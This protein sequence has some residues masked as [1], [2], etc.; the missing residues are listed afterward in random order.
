MKERDALLSNCG[1]YR[2]LLTRVW[3]RGR[4]LLL[5]IMLN[6]STADA[7]NND[8][9][10]LRVMSLAD[11]AGYG[12]I[13][14]TN[15]YAY[16]ATNP[17]NLKAA[18]A[19]IGSANDGY[20]KAALNKSADVVC[21]WGAHPM[22][23]RRAPAVLSLIRQAGKTPKVWRLTK[24]GLPSHPLYLPKAVRPFVWDAAA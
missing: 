18:S 5:V 10:I 22:A 19:P 24:D 3:D 1:T 14:V 21:A 11:A 8:P 4:P 7:T 2:W 13:I 16:R 15:L 20:I 17:T 9:T 12:G 23:A 6:P